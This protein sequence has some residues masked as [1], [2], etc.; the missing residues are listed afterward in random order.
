MQ[1]P[2]PLHLHLPIRHLLILH[3]RPCRRRRESPTTR[4]RN[5]KRCQSSRARQSPSNS[6]PASAYL[7]DSGPLAVPSGSLTVQ[8]ETSSLV[9][10]RRRSSVWRR[11]YQSPFNSVAMFT[12]SW[13]SSY[14]MRSRSTRLAVPSHTPFPAPQV[15][16]SGSPNALASTPLPPPVPTVGK[17]S[18][19]DCTV[20]LVVAQTKLYVHVPRIAV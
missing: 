7:D 2:L 20:H 18:S 1:R 17:H 12:E 3:G 8:T 9:P 14:S 6:D 10:L 11:A 13:R 4:L 19:C 15:S 5:G 16:Y